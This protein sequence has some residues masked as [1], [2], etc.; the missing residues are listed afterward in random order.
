L[1]ARAGERYGSAS[2]GRSADRRG[3]TFVDQGPGAARDA[4]NRADEIAEAAARCF[5]RHGF[6]RTSVREIAQEVGLTKSMIHYYFPSKAALILEVKRRL[7]Q[8]YLTRAQQALSTTEPDPIKRSSAALR[9]MW[10]S[11]RADPEEFRL[12]LEVW[13]EA[14]RDPALRAQL[15]P[16][17]TEARDRITMGIRESIG[18]L[19]GRLPAPIESVAMM[20][21]AQINGLQVQAVVEPVEGIDAIYE[22]FV[23]LLAGWIKR[24]RDRSVRSSGA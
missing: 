3:D 15:Q 9:S 1:T 20:I 10:E 24:E 23:Q 12:T 13:S 4:V 8:R 7:Y 6:V 19:A 21:L 11:V 2:V 18:D 14:A 22:M 17:Q 16:L 5:A